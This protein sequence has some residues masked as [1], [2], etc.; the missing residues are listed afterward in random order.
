MVRPTGAGRQAS[1]QPEEAAV[2]RLGGGSGSATFR[3]DEETVGQTTA[4]RDTGLPPNSGLGS[5]NRQL[6]VLSANFT[7]AINGAGGGEGALTRQLANLKAHMAAVE[8]QGESL[9][10]ATRAVEEEY[11]RVASP[12]AG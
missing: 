12:G 11:R 10:S 6:E 5:V 7:A 9:R 4:S 1:P 2:A 3:A 8:A